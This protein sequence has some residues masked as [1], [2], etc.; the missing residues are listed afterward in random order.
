[1]RGADR[2]LLTAVGRDAS[3]PDVVCT[4]DVRSERRSYRVDAPAGDSL[5]VAVAQPRDVY[6]GRVVRRR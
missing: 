5:V 6:L 3:G 2:L 1:V 4:A